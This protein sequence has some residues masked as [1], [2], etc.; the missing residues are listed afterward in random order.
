MDILVA[1]MAA[2]KSENVAFFMSVQELWKGSKYPDRC[3][4]W[5]LEHKSRPRKWFKIHK[6]YRG[7]D[8]IVE[9]RCKNM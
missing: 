4:E 8:M 2:P 5:S 7:H 9:Q 6:F 1:D 3:L